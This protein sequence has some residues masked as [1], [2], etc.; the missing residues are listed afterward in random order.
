MSNI[1]NSLMSKA[2]AKRPRDEKNIG[3]PII[4]VPRGV[5]SSSLITLENVENLLRCGIFRA[6]KET[7][8]SRL[9]PFDFRRIMEENR[10]QNYCVIHDPTLLK[11]DDW[12]VCS[13]T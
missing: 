6:G 2:R 8:P 3:K 13:Y 5:T 1:I 4:V 9:K 11:N 12:F 10:T 7:I